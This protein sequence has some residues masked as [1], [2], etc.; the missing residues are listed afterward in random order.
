[1][2]LIV[3]TYP[4]CNQNVRETVRALADA[5]LLHCLHTTLS[6]KESDAALALLPAGAKQELLR[7]RFPCPGEQIV[8]HPFP[9]VLRVLA[10]RLRLG[11]LTAPGA[12][13]NP[14][15]VGIALDKQASHF[16]GRQSRAI[17][18]VFGYEDSCLFTFRAAAA[19]NKFKIYELTI[20]YWQTVIAIYNEDAE[21]YP[22]WRDTWNI[23]DSPAHFQRKTEEAEL[24]DRILCISRF[25]YNSLPEQLKGKARVVDYGFPP[26]ASLDV[27]EGP[28]VQRPLRVLFV[29]QLTQRKGLADLFEA[30][31]LLNRSDVKL[32]LLGALCAPMEFYRQQYGDFEYHA[33]LPHSL[34]MDFMKTCDVLAFPSTCEGRGLVQ[35]EALRCGLPV[36]GT[37]SA[38]SDDLIEDGVNG[39]IVPVR[40]PGALAQ[41]IAWFADNPE[42]RLEMGQQ[43]IARAANLGW[44]KYHSQ[45]IEVARELL[46][47]K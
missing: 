7:R 12:P 31:K 30:F 17:D 21:R 39:F 26:A 22:A 25:V 46:T 15:A 33:P 34:V 41:K 18:G 32:V 4:G 8:T 19:A 38:T 35:L 2:A 44:D 9:E 3:V 36:I 11:K 5:K 16:I 37:V 45:V 27:V 10:T 14:I 47:S 28:R 6:F 20:P 24:A 13:L 42:R 40:T 29:G 1:M 23:L 43:A